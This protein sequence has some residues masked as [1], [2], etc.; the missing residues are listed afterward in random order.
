MLKRAWELKMVE[1]AKDAVALMVED[2][3][4]EAIQSQNVEL[5]KFLMKNFDTVEDFDAPGSLEMWETTRDIIVNVFRTNNVEIIR[6]FVTRWNINVRKL[7]Q[8]VYKGIIGSWCLDKANTFFLMPDRSCPHVLETLKYLVE[9]CG[10]SI[11]NNKC[12]HLIVNALRCSLKCASQAM[13]DDIVGYLLEHGADVNGIH[14]A[15]RDDTALSWLSD[16]MFPFTDDEQSERSVFLMRQLVEEYGAD[17]NLPRHNP[18]LRLCVAAER[19]GVAR[20]LLHHGAHVNGRTE[21]GVP[22]VLYYGPK[23]REFWL[24]HA[25]PCQWQVPELWKGG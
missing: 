25:A 3:L 16:D 19:F 22:F 12:N 2:A 14:E 23:A 24:R 20:Y 9:E 6:Y 17:P 7:D 18:P 13:R 4:R 1:T 11:K 8:E 15:Y 21:R 10:V 5:I